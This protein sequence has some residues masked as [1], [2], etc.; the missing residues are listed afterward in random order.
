MADESKVVRAEPLTQKHYVP[1]GDV[2]SA[3]DDIHPTPANRGTAE[4]FNYLT[5]VENRRQG[6]SQNQAQANLCLFRCQP[7]ISSHDTFFEVSVLEKHPLSTQAFIPMSGVNRFLVIVCLGEEAPDLSTLRAFLASSTQGITYHPGVWHHP[8]VAMDQQ[9]DFA[10]LV[11]ED[12]T[13]DDCLTVELQENRV[14]VNL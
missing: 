5:K 12:G 9:S 2:I 10:C 4:R 7:Q 11:W 6:N 13:I 14:K 3:R 1:Y 8:L